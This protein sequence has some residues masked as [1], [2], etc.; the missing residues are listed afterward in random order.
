MTFFSKEFR[1]LC[2]LVAYQSLIGSILEL[3]MIAHRRL[4]REDQEFEA[5]SGY[6]VRPSFKGKEK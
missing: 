3:T 5:S 6:I 4:K 2:F 1:F